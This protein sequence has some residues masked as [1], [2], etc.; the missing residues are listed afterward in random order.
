MIKVDVTGSVAKL[1]LS[2]A[3]FDERQ[4]SVSDIVEQL[5]EA[6]VCYGILATEIAKIVDQ[7]GD[8]KRTVD[9]VVVARQREPQAGKPAAI[10]RIL[11]NDQIA[12]PGDAIAE[13]GE[14]VAAVDGQTVLGKVIKVAAPHETV[15]APGANTALIGATRL[16]ATI[17]GTVTSTGE[18]IS[19]ESL[20]SV[21]GDKLTASM[22]IHSESSA[23]MPITAEMVHVSLEIAGVVYGVDDQKIQ[24]AISEAL[25]TDSVLPRRVVAEGRPSIAGEDARLEYFSEIDQAIGGKREDGSMDFHDRGTIRNFKSGVM[26]CR[27]IPPTAGRSQVDVYGL[28]EFARPGKD[29]NFVAG[30]NV[31]KRGEEFW[32][33]IDG[34]LMIGDNVVKVSNVYS[35]AGD[36]DLNT[37][38]LRHDKGALQIKGTVRSGFTAYAATHIMVGELVEDATLESGGDIEIKGGVIHANNGSIRAKGGV[39]AK[40]AQ[41]A[42]IRA[43]GDIIINGAAMN[44]EL[45]AGSQIIVA[46]RKARLAG[47]IAHAKGGFRVEQLGSE[48]GAPTRVKI[49]LDRREIQSLE[50]KIKQI[51]EAI[52]AGEAA[53]SDLANREELLRALFASSNRNGTIIVNGTVYPGV[54]VTICSSQR[55]FT[56]EYRHCKIWWDKDRGIRVSP[57]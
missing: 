28:R 17:Y 14:P 40:F 56:E 49:E 45:Y 36:I 44:C 46:G 52:A 35:V 38:N 31:E 37:G 1:S 3:D 57:L 20:V 41:N 47:G 6:G 55:N 30:E 27:R 18:T 42:K 48:L 7:Q 22:S 25:E 5:T 24:S 23:G 2:P 43:G 21:E 53:E 34:A 26:I 8:Q 19:V 9:G 12:A 11:R 10:K 15:L 50:L 54:H 16:V 29:I 32:S 51:E 4:I 33:M 39:R 13:L